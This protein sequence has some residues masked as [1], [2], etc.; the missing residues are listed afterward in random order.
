MKA[1][2]AKRGFTLI[3]LMIVVAI[4]GILAAI[5]IP[6]F[7]RFQARS[8]QS[9][10]K[11]NLK[12]L[13][14]AE[15]SF[16]QEKDKYDTYIRSIG[17]SPERGNRYAYRVGTCAGWEQRVLVDLTTHQNDECI[18]VDTLKYPNMVAAVATV[19][20]GTLTWATGSNATITPGVGG[21]CPTCNF[22]GTAAGNVDNEATGIDTWYIS[23]ADST[24]V[25]ACPSGGSAEGV[26][27]GDPRNTYNDVNCD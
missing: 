25:A 13:F 5:A 9:E 12:A 23:S 18:E 17:F 11:S 19:G 26:P 10:A 27:A 7:I 3:E 14:T 21:A 2:L 1:S 24:N 16:F 22:T 6:N 8:K 15:R 4:I 20:T